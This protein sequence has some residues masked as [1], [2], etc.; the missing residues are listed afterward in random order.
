MT[1]HFVA[2]QLPDRDGRHR[3][4]V[5]GQKSRWR[6][7]FEDNM[8]TVLEDSHVHGKGLVGWKSPGVAQKHL[9]LKKRLYET[10]ELRLVAMTF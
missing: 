6:E 5:Y 1:E 3:V 10:N 2:L 8:E 4:R 9:E 7:A